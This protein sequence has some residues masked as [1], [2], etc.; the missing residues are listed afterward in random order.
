MTITVEALYEQALQLSQEERRRLVLLLARETP[1]ERSISPL[2]Q[3]LRA[4]R[5]QIIANGLTLLDRDALEAE[6]ADR[7]GER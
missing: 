7:R 4:A 6:I 5:A 2:G 1:P 3:R